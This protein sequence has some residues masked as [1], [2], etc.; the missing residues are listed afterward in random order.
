MF[1]DIHNHIIPYVDD[2]SE[3]IATSLEMLKIASDEGIG[4]IIAT[5][6]FIYGAINN[7][8]QNIAQSGA[9]V[10][11]A[12]LEKGIELMFGSEVFIC[13]EICSLVQDGTVCRLNNSRYI[14][15]EL[16]ML[17][18][19]TYTIDML[20][21][22]QLLGYIPIIAHPERNKVFQNNQAQLFKLVERGILVQVNATSITKLYG[23]DVQKVAMGFLEGGLVHFVATDS[24]TNRGRSPR[25]LKSHDIISSE[26]GKDVANNLFTKN[27]QAVIDDVE[28]FVEAPVKKK[29]NFFVGLFSF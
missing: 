16:P 26:F 27:G 4:K 20:F 7:C 10:A 19:P 3:N 11:N 5:P 2:G 24:H 1:V 18:I 9:E 25:M 22:L 13:P 23:K 21:N 29:K 8:T 28:I 14:L 15:I 6:H 17:S 12:A